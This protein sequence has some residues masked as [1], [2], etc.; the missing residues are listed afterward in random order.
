MNV[1]KG[2][3]TFVF[4]LGLAGSAMGQSQEAQDAGEVIAKGFRLEGGLLNLS[5]GDVECLCGGVRIRKFAPGHVFKNGDELRTGSDG[6]VEILL[7]PGYYLRLAN[8]TQ[9]RLMDLTPENLTTRL[10][11]GSAILEIAVPDVSERFKWMVNS[12]FDLVTVNTPRD[13]YTITSSGAFR[14][15]VTAEANS[16][17]KVLKGSV[18]VAGS[19]V[20]EGKTASLNNG[21]PVMAPLDKTGA[22]AFDTW[23]RERGANLVLTNKSLKKMWWYK[24]MQDDDAYIGVLDP[25][26]PARAASERVVSAQNGV[27][28]FVEQGAVLR[29]GESTWSKLQAGDNLA[30][31]DRAQTAPQS[32]AELRPYPSFDF[33]LGGATEIAY[34][35][36]QDGE[37]SVTVLRGAV[38]VIILVDRN[39]KSKWGN[40][41]TVRAQNSEYQIAEAGIYRFNVLPEGK[42][43]MLV[44][45]GAVKAGGGVI[46]AAKRIVH[47]GAGEAVLPLD[48]REQDSLDVW[49]FKKK[50]GGGVRRF[51]RIV[52][53]GGLWFLNESTGQHTFVP[54]GWHYK[55]PYG[56]DYSTRYRSNSPILQ[57]GPKA[58][59]PGVK[60]PALPRMRT[61]GKPGP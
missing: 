55:S 33:Y 13:E 15:N 6:R 61:P 7:N 14:F 59:Q 42:S 34:A 29:S 56:G 51:K 31:G 48:Q 35:E 16:E 40:T 49:S 30:N 57:L 8:N 24:K 28:T 50:T 18:V 19:K 20:D 12:A 53:A 32:R 41:F 47:S 25:A 52:S 4:L 60:D 36:Q 44:Y 37:V 5:E 27:V 11:R 54:A 23:S 26:D 10:A 45:E 38:V 21:R 22:D 1:T 46:K 39:R 43:E 9:A 17:V 58:V 3:L 2:F